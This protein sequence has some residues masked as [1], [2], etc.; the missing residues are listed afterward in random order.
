MDITPLDPNEDPYLTL[1]QYYEIQGSETVLEVASPKEIKP[2]LKARILQFRTYNIFRNQYVL[3]PLRRAYENTISFIYLT[4][5][6]T[7]AMEQFQRAIGGWTDHQAYHDALLVISG[8]L[9]LF[10]FAT[11]ASNDC[12]GY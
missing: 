4:A 2:T 1:K 8:V 3:T 12:L 9:T 11:V 6:V 10:F 7:F 5:T